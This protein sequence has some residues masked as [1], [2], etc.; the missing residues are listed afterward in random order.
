[1]ALYMECEYLTEEEKKARHELIYLFNPCLKAIFDKSPKFQ[2]YAYN[3]CRQ[4]AVFSSVFLLKALK[5]YH[6]DTY[7]GNFSD[8]IQGQKTEY[9][10]AFAIAYNDKRKLLI[11]VSRTERQLLFKTTVNIVYPNIGGYKNCK[12]LSYDKFDFYSMFLIQEP[13]YITGLKPAEAYQEAEEMYN[14]LKAKPKSEQIN[15]AHKI[16]SKTTK[17]GGEFV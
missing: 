1:M 6:I 2:A 17:I 9:E 15:F 5:G 11:D 3:S 7:E 12:L 8:V 4:T 16:Y 14:W 13:E 10:H